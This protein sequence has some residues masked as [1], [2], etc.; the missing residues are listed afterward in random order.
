MDVDTAP[1]QTILLAEDVPEI[2]RLI[3]IYLQQIGYYVLAAH[4]GM[5]ALDIYRQYQEEVDLL[6]TDMKM[7]R[8]SGQELANALRSVQPAIPVLYISGDMPLPL[9][10]P[11]LQKP[12]RMKDLESLVH[13]LLSQQI[14]WERKSYGLSPG[15][16]LNSI[17]SEKGS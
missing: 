7:P 9:P 6:I 17:S 3:R 12:F 8:M 4:D 1:P 13:A 15:L 14:S 10:T 11:F 16:E 2:R 5:E